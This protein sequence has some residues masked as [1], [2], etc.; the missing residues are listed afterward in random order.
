V[1]VCVGRAAGGEK[2]FLA[3]NSPS[4]N[5]ARARTH[6]YN[7]Y[8]FQRDRRLRRRRRRHLCVDTD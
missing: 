8:A 6:L 7:K 4:V 2:P 3:H 1:C 5:F